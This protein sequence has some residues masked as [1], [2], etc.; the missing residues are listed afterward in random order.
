MNKKLIAVA[1]AGI[2]AAPAAYADISAYGR[3]H[4]ALVL[5]DSGPTDTQNVS[6]VASRFGFR[7]SGDIGNGMNA[8]ARYEFGTKTDAAGGSIGN[9]LS[10]VGLSGPF[11]SISLGQQWSAFYQ[12]VGT[13]ASPNIANGPGQHLGPFRTGNTLQYSNSLGPVS[14]TVD[15][16]VDDDDPV[17]GN[18]NGFGLGA[19]LRP[20]DNFLISGGYDTDDT[21]NKDTMGVSAATGFGALSFAVSHQ[22]QDHGDLE[23]KSTLIAVG[24]S[25]TDQ[26]Y[27][28]AAFSQ[29]EM[30]SADAAATET[31]RMNAS[32]TY[33]IGGGLRTYIEF[34]N[35]DNGTTDKDI[36]ALGLRMD[37]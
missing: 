11:G 4:N 23:H 2:V 7:G 31:D 37:F 15:A 32:A 1:V 28:S 14:L 9:R 25:V 17:D 24:S 20:M 35:E 6:G 3:I 21:N 16:R 36:F 19:T 34:A 8:F 27:L 22:Q 5:E 10:F 30:E 12:N 29:T 18:G 26:L 13:H 33:R